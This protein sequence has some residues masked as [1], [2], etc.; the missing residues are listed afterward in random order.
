MNIQNLQ[1]AL[2]NT[3]KENTNETLIIGYQKNLRLNQFASLRYYNSKMIGQP[4]ETPCDEGVQI[5]QLYELIFLIEAL[6][7]NSETRATQLASTFRLTSQKN[8]LAS[9]GLKFF[10][11]GPL[12]DATTFL[13]TDY[14][15]RTRFTAHFYA[16]D[17]RIDA[18]G[19]IEDYSLELVAENQDQTTISDET[20]NIG[21]NNGES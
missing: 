21:D 13:S 9:Q 14:N 4:N 1:T 11:C 7:T 18:V 16:Q 17:V 10:K 3:L 12:Q 2:L 5:T 15:L 19:L 6:G 8:K 20:I